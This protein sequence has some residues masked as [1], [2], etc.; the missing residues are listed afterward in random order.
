MYVPPEVE[1]QQAEVERGFYGSGGYYPPSGGG[2]D[3][4]DGGYDGTTTPYFHVTPLD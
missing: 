3:Y 1:V 4:E 2:G